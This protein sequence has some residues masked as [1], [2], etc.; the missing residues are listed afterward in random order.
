[1]AG[2]NRTATDVIFE[3]NFRGSGQESPLYTMNAWSLGWEWLASD[4]ATSR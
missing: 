3:I 2:K 1:M 4:S